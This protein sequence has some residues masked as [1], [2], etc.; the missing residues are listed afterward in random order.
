MAFGFPYPRF[1]ESRTFHLGEH[2]LRVAVGCALE[3]LGWP[4]TVPLGKD[5]EARVPTTNWSW[6]HD[7]KVRILPGG[8]VEAESKS[9]YQEMFLDLGRN[10]RNVEKFF[11]RVEQMA[12]Q[13]KGSVT[14]Q[15]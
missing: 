12:G 14:A 5:F 7:V 11:A 9:A 8:V 10:K 2:E 3:S 6:H 13:S 15:T 4:Y 1:R